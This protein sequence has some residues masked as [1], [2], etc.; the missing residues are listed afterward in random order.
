MPTKLFVLLLFGSLWLAAQSTTSAPYASSIPA[1]ITECDGNQ[2]TQGGGGAIWLFE[3][4]HGQAMWKYGAIANLTVTAFDG[5]TIAIHREDPNPS[6]SSPRF[7]DPGK[8]S[9]GV[10][11]ADYTGTIRGSRIYGTVVWNGGGSGTW[12][13]TIPEGLC[14]P[15]EECPLDV[16]K[17]MQL[18]HNALQAKLDSS[19]LLCYRI[20]A[21]QGNGDAKGL[22]GTMIL[23]GIGTRPNPPQAVPLLTDSANG[24]SYYGMLGLSLMYEVGAGTPKDPQRAAY[25]KERANRRI[26]ELQAIQAQR[27]MLGEIVSS[28]LGSLFDGGSSSSQS[29]EEQ[30]YRRALQRDM[31]NN[32]VRQIE[33]NH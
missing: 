22:A 16:N 15:I 6:Y 27:A 7:A 24:G 14:D 13:A 18:A 1:A 25:W 11:F 23:S 2:C 30:E 3:G 29:E 4:A 9:D 17:V 19:A 31:E 28:F 20:A 26:E 33:G 5:H 21:A 12:Y 8:R 10:F 32:R